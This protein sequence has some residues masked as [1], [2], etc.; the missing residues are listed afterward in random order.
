MFTR[1][2]L[3]PMFA[4]SLFGQAPPASRPAVT[5][6]SSL[7]EQLR[8]THSRQDWFVPANQ[9]VEGLTPKQASWTDG[10]GNHSVGQ[11]A[12]HLI[13]WN[14]QQLARMK[15][16][17]AEKPGA[18]DE[19]FNAFD[20]ANWSATVRQLNEVLSELE[21]VVETMPEE[22]LQQFAS[23]I[24]HIATHNAYHVGQILYVRKL[25]GSWDPSRGVK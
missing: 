13:F 21:K 3:L 22:K 5:L 1:A 14:R 8:T 10:S 20:A 19:T 24:G 4:L 25:Q 15:S 7:L 12:N 6:R 17:P 18:N 16:E 9:A 2:L 11:L 23:A